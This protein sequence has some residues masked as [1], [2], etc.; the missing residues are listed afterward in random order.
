M[1]ILLSLQ[2]TYHSNVPKKFFFGILT[3]NYLTFALDGDYILFRFTPTCSK[4]AK[5]RNCL[6]VLK[7]CGNDA[8][9]VACTAGG[10]VV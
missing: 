9:F 7:K 10:A 4:E 1:H 8:G 2:N 5:D 3:S 6:L